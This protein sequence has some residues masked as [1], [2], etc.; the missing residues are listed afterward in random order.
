MTKPIQR[1]SYKL[2]ISAICLLLSLIPFSSSLAQVGRVTGR[3]TEKGTGE[4]L[5]GAN[6][7]IKGTN[8]GMAT[9]AEGRFVL[10][11]VPAGPQTLVISYIGYTS[12]EKE[13]NVN[14]GS[15]LSIDIEL[16]W[17]GVVGSD[18][19]VTAQAR[20]QMSAINQQLTSNRITNVVSADRIRELP[21]VNA[22]ESIGRLPGIAIQRSG[23]E[24]NKISI[25]GLSPKFNS[26]TVNGVRVPSV[27]TNDRS[28]DLS[29]VSSN[30]LDG[31]EVTKALTPD[32]DAD[33]L[34]G[35]VD[36]RL[37]SDPDEIFADL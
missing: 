20:G 3:V 30:M 23:G 5:F 1:K 24:A 37:K 29:L 25:R 18:V 15:T 31:I 36:L 17:V 11:S 33:A 14:S 32:L 12:V 28:V 21:D 13:I 35:T 19:I 16:E 26:V 2:W 34:G 4:M 6:V 27:D 9:D 8:L 22:A 10:S 7:I